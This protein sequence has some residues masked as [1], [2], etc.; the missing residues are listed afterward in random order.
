MQYQGEAPCGAFRNVLWQLMREFNYK[1]TLNGKLFA[2]EE[3]RAQSNTRSVVSAKLLKLETT[4]K[5]VI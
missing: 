1:Q 5:G 2:V 4:Y 3:T